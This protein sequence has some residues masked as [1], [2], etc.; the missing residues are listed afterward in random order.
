MDPDEIPTRTGATF[1]GWYTDNNTFTTR[2][3]FP[4]TPVTKD[5]T[6]YAKWIITVSFETNGGGTIPSQIINSGSRP[7]QPNTPARIGYIFDGWYT[8]ST[9]S[10]PYNFYVP[11]TED[12]TLYAKWVIIVLTVSFETD[13]GDPVPTNQ[14]IE[15]GS[16]PTQPDTPA[17]IGYFFDGWYTDNTFFSLYDFSAPVTEDITIYAKWVAAVTVNFETSGGDTVPSQSIKPGTMA[18]QPYDPTQTGYFFDGWYTDNTFSTPYDFSAPVTGDITLYA[19]WVNPVTINFETNGGSTVPSQIVH[20]GS[21][22]TQPVD[23][24]RSEY[25]F[26]GWYTDNKTFSSPYDFSAELTTGI[27]LYAKW[28]FEY[29]VWVPEGSFMMGSTPTDTN[30]DAD[31][32]PQH[33]VTITKGYYMAKFEVTQALFESVMGYNPSVVSKGGDLPVETVSW[34]EAVE[35]CNKLSEQEGLTPVYE[36][37]HRTP[38]TGNKITHMTVTVH[39]DHNGYRLPTEAEW[40]YA[41]KGGNGSPGDFLYS[42]ANID[43][44]DS[45]AWYLVNSGNTTHAVGTKAPNGLG[46]YDM[47]GN[48]W[49]WCWD[50]HSMSYPSS[51]LSDPKGPGTDT[52][53]SNTATRIMRGGCYSSLAEITRSANR[54][55]HVPNYITDISGNSEYQGF[56]IVCN[57]P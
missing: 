25:K 42:G 24:V 7:T 1:D 57:G 53:N 32:K 15:F 19:K 27:T 49:E 33:G 45:A 36:L 41:A 5:I 14:M 37:S 12:T 13:G 29:M 18:I 54:F 50:Q 35:F 28:I 21:K 4:S 39:W 31:E 20:Y 44:I 56:R 51:H 16:T 23:P 38:A 48:V 34:Y 30:A 22:V 3:I 26:M 8:D 9:F 10:I 11:V 6:L 17:R 2:Y 47:S 46:I 40:E 55:N 52:V 43:T